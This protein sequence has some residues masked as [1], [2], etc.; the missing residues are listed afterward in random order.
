[1]TH[2]IIA[3]ARSPSSPLAER[4]LANF[5]ITLFPRSEERAAQRSVGGVSKLSDDL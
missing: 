4:G 5:K 3:Y 2:P 1:M